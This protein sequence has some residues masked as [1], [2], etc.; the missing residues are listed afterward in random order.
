VSHYSE[1]RVTYPPPPPPPPPPQPQHE[2]SNTRTRTDIVPIAV[3]RSLY[4]EDFLDLIKRKKAS[5]RN[6]MQNI[7]FK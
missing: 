7:Q 1:S 6:Q 5:V 2:Q 3:L 4:A